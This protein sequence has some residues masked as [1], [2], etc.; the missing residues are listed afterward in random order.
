MD[1]QQR[2]QDDIIILQ[3][4]GNIISGPDASKVNDKLHEL[5]EK[6]D[7]RIVADLSKVSWMNSSGLGI[8]ISALT[9][10]RN[11][12]GELK[13]AAATEKIRNLLTITKL[14]NVIKLYDTVDEAIA[15]F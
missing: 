2:A 13:V 7:T 10:L 5:S 14:T 9:T 11:A 4:S 3:L 15:D 1:I 12:G 6:G 8:L